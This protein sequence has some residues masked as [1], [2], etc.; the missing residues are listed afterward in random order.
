MCAAVLQS[1]G[2]RQGTT[3]GAAM[4]QRGGGFDAAPRTRSPPPPRKRPWRHGHVPV[5]SR[6]RPGHVPVTSRSLT[7]GGEGRRNRTVVQGPPQKDWQ[8]RM[9]RGSQQPSQAAGRKGAL[10]GPQAHVPACP[11]CPR[12]QRIPVTLA[13]CCRGAGAGKGKRARDNDEDDDADYGDGRNFSQQPSQVAL[14]VALHASRNSAL[15]LLR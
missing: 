10:P 14:P 11:C 7:F 2:P 3:R 8:R 1:S 4:A 5:T 13:V 15:I 12:C 6:S 9:P